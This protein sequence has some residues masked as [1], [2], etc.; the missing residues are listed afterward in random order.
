MRKITPGDIMDLTAYAKE[1]SER[2]K[3]IIAVKARRR[4]ALGPH[5]VVMFENYDTMWHQIHEMLYMEQ[6]V[7][8]GRPLDA[9]AISAQLEDELA[10]YNPL[11]PDG[12]ELVAT[13]MFEIANT[14]QRDALLD[15]IGGVEHRF[16]ICFDDTEIFG[17]PETDTER[18]SAD[19]R[20]SSVHFVHFPFDSP[21]KK[22]FCAPGKRITVSCGHEN[23]AH[24]TKLNEEARAM[25]AKDFEV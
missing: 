15:I 6:G 12:N 21:A 23:Y 16:S 18:T 1:R 19:G 2:R 4:I 3:K 22:L 17:I 25:L 11:I 13:I 7:N 20:S 8:T 14:D 24:M 9:A 5:A 10:A